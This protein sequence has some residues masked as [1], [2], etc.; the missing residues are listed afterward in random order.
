MSAGGPPYQVS[1]NEATRQGIRRLIRLS[2]MIGVRDRLVQSLTQIEAAL[3][4]HPTTWGDPYDTRPALR[5]VR[6]RRIYD[7][8]LVRY[9]VH[10]EQLV[11][12]LTG[13]SPV[14]H[15]PLWIGEG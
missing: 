12:W 8:L 6:Y 5:L 2:I 3:Q 9:A 4:N 1:M 14:L 11:V 13:I 10:Q 15:S 7:Q